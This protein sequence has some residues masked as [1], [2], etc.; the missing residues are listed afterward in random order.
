MAIDR[1]IICN[2][3]ILMAC[4]SNYQECE[5]SKGNLISYSIQFKLWISYSIQ[6]NSKHNKFKLW[7]S[8]LIQF[9]LWISYLIQFNSKHNKFKLWFSLVFQ[10]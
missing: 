6:F 1:T 9:K 4:K 8:Y 3:L 5:C 10:E 7:I 2:Q